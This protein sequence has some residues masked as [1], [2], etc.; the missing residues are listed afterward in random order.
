MNVTKDELKIINGSEVEPKEVE[1]LWYPYIPL[2]KVTMIHG[3]PGDGKSTFMLNI[4][5]ALTRGEPLPF[6]DEGSEPMNVIYQ[7]TEDDLDDTVIPR[8]MKAGGD[9]NRIFFIDEREKSLSFSDERIGETIRQTDAKLIIFNPISSYLGNDVSINLANEVRSRMNY[10]IEVAKETKCAV[11]VIGHMNKMSGAKAMYRASGSIDIIG[12]ARSS[13][14]VGQSPDNP[15][16]R[17][18][19]VQK[20]NLAEKGL[21]IEF[22]IEDGKV[23]P[24]QQVD[25]SA[26]ELLNSSA[27]V[28]NRSNTKTEKAKEVLVEMLSA[29]EKAQQEIIAKMTELGISKRT[30]ELAKSELGI[31]SRRNGSCWTWRLS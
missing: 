20:C 25:V 19:A 8:F 23:T 28:G 17:I 11:V 12:A 5:A 4:A 31:K 16:N 27:S 21:S 3:D 1:W 2:G 29:G 30:A 24:L 26:D 6:M 22:T 15:D 14:V 18:M 10:L 9:L 7:N 13:L